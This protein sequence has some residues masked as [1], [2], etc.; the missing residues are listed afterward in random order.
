MFD[1]FGFMISLCNWKHITEASP[2]RIQVCKDLE[3]NEERF[4]ERGA[5][6]VVT[7]EL[8]LLLPKQTWMKPSIELVNVGP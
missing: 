4:S 1:P 8:A 2:G 6:C 7:A 5:V 3:G